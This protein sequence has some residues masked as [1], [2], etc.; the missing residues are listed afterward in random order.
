MLMSCEYEGRELQLAT[1]ARD[2]SNANKFTVIVGKNGTGKSRLLRSIVTSFVS[3]REI[4]GRDRSFNS[5]QK[6]PAINILCENTPSCV[7]ALSTS[8]FDRFPI[9]RLSEEDD[10]YQYLGLRGLGSRNLSVAFMSRT[11]GALLSAVTVDPS[12]A[13]TIQTVLGYLGYYGFIEARFVTTTRPSILEAVLRAKDPHD[14]LSKIP[15]SSS[16]T[17]S[18]REDRFIY[19]LK[20]LNNNQLLK[21]L[22]ALDRWY[23]TTRKPRFD[24]IIDANGVHCLGTNE[25]LDE[26]LLLLFQL[27]FFQL[28]DV[29]LQKKTTAR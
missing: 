22:E 20:K 7:I 9:G 12:Q 5:N 29:G 25:K 6:S 28:R 2:E 27:G 23:F 13:K 17:F 24:L 21:A 10:G 3:I 15:N 8:P 14:S 19:N 1:C 4:E 26:S 16:S 11:L 18:M